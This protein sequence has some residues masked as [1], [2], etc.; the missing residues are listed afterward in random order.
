M[1]FGGGNPLGS[2]GSARLTSRRDAA[3]SD[4]TTSGP[5]AVPV[6]LIVR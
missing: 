1:A 3:A 2:V 4:A 5:A 6:S